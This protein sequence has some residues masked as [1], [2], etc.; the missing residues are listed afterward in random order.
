MTVLTFIDTETTGLDP[1]IHQA[2]EVCLWRED[3]PEPVTLWLPHTLDHADPQ[4]LRIG[5]Y[6]DR[7][8]KP[9][10]DDH[11]GRDYLLDQLQG[12]TLVGAN[13][14]FDAAML[15]GF[16]GT[17]VWHYRFINVS[18]GAMWLFGWDRPRSLLDTATA[19]RDAGYDIP[20]PDHT[21]E[22]DVR[23]TRAVY[24]GLRQIATY[25]RGED[26]SA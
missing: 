1:R 5:G 22:G 7:D 17:E 2:Y 23:T 24:E 9:W 10:S 11:V 19:V 12:V 6:F 8:Q 16:I 13:P 4:A 15:R 3:A 25:L 26:R 20:E 21:A 18:D 14:G